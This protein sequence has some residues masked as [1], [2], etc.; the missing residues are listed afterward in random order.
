[1]TEITEREPIPRLPSITE[2]QRLR[3]LFGVTQ[4]ELAA[5]MGVS[6]RTV[7]RWESGKVNPIGPNLIKYAN[8]LAKWRER[9]RQRR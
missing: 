2:R 7:I 8:V 4:T 5:S 6:E 1:M 9:S 3:E